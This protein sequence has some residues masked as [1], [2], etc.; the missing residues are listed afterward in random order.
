MLCLLL[1]LWTILQGAKY[2]RPKW[3][4][5]ILFLPTIAM[6]ETDKSAADLY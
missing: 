2:L 3:C 1:N 4:M 5:P 6:D